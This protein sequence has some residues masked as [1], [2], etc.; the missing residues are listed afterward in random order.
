MLTQ[1]AS[2]DAPTH[3]SS[4]RLV[5]AKPA[6]AEIGLPYSTLRDLAFRGLVPVVKIGRAWYFDRRDLERLIERQKEVIT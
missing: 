2:Y 3:Q 4:T 1:S 6:A 5:A